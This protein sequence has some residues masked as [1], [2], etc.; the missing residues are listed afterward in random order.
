[1]PASVPDLP[2]RLIRWKQAFSHGPHSIQ[3]EL[4]Q[5]VWSHAAFRCVA[6][7]IQMNMAANKGRFE[8][9]TLVVD[10]LGNGYWP[11]TMMGV[12][13]LL[14]RGS[15]YGDRGVSSLQAVLNDAQSVRDQLTRRVFV[16]DIAG[17][18]YDVDAVRRAHD[19]YFFAQKAQSSGP[20]WIPRELDYD[21][22]E[23]RHAVFDGLSG[24]EA[25]R[26]QPI[27]VMRIEV[28]GKLQQRL[29]TAGQAVS[30]HATIHY[31]HTASEESRA[32]RGMDSWNLDDA[33][34]SLQ[35]LVETAELMGRWF[36]NEG[37]GPPMPTP[38]DNQLAY[39]D[40]GLLPNGNTTALE[41]IWEELDA[42]SRAWVQVEDAAL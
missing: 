35:G 8:L 14:D 34:R 7:A 37:V 33:W 10:L 3:N 28:F 31:A 18:R 13:R 17:L 39:L 32:G 2:T 19:A 6:H 22:I 11:I 4:V 25:A 30:D 29:D 15:L 9:N 12:R 36:A 23:A 26:R 38:Q 21:I 41:Q 1:M 20:V 16:E 40:R 5:L 42:S 24:V 27:D